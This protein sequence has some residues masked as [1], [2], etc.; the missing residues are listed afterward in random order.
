MTVAVVGGQLKISLTETE[1]IK[2]NIDRVF[3]DK[4]GDSSGK[5][6]VAL[7]EL[8]SVKVGFKPQ[9]TDFLIEMHPIFTGGCEIYYIPKPSVLQKA[10]VKR[11]SLFEFDTADA[12]LQAAE[13]LFKC[14]RARYLTSVLYKLN[15]R[16][17][18][19]VKGLPTNQHRTVQLNFADG[20][21]SSSQELVKTVTEGRVLVPKNAIAVIGSA[22]CR[23]S[24]E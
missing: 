3:F 6:L 19:A 2:Y 21:L 18:L 13:W 14:E 1:I 9:T 5:A 11:W 22:M 20:H 4:T 17:R 12:M 23:Q 24:L 16:Y 15:S 7:L 8:A 10:E